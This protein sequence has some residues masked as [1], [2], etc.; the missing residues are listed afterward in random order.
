MSPGSQEDGEEGDPGNSIM[1]DSS[2][3]NNQNS[4]LNSEHS[5]SQLL[6]KAQKK[7]GI[8]EP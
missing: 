8:D 1:T 2:H 5:H 4:D 6:R 3:H 7:F